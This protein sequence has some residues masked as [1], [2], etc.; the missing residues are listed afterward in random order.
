MSITLSPEE[1]RQFG[2]LFR[3]YDSE[4]TGVI[5]G[6]AAYKLFINSGLSSAQL[7]QIW[8]IA[9]AENRGFLD[10]NGFGKALR[11]IYHVQQG[12][13]LAPRLAT[14]PASLPDFTR[15]AAPAPPAAPAQRTSHQP[16]QSVSSIGSNESIAAQIPP[17]GTSDKQRFGSLFDKHAREGFIDG[18]SARGIFL[19]A[20]LANDAL[21][22]IWSLVDVAGRGSLR[23]NEFILAMHLIQCTMRKSLPVLPSQLPSSW[24]PWLE[25][26]TPWRI[27]AQDKGKFDRHFSQLDTSG[28]GYIGA[29]EAV[30]FLKKSNLSDEDL[31]QVWDL[32]DYKEEGRLDR[33]GFAIAM[34]LINRKL[35]GDALPSR[36]PPELIE[37]SGIQGTAVSRSMSQ[38]VGSPTA[39]SPITSPQ[40]QQG[41]GQGGPLAPP[42]RKGAA[43]SSLQDLVSLDDSFFGK[44][45]IA[46]PVLSPAATG[47]NVQPHTGSSQGA[48]Q[49]S[50]QLSGQQP[51]Q[52]NQNSGS[53]QTPP[54][55]QAHQPV[56]VPKSSFGQ[57]LVKPQQ[58]AQ[59]QAATEDL[60]PL[61]NEKLDLER[62]IPSATAEAEQS[63]SQLNSVQEEKSALEAQ[64]SELKKR[65]DAETARIYS[66]QQ[67]TKSLREEIA[68]LEK[69]F[70]LRSSSFRALE[71]QHSETSRGLEEATSRKEELAS[72]LAQL[73]EQHTTHQ[74]TLDDLLRESQHISG[75]AE[76]HRQR[77][78]S[79]E[80]ELGQLLNEIE[81]AKTGRDE[82]ERNAR[83]ARERA[84][85]IQSEVIKA[86][87][88]LQQ[89]RDQTSS[90]T[91]AAESYQSQAQQAE[92][93]LSSI[94]SQHASTLS[95]RE[96]SVTPQAAPKE[97][98]S[99]E[100]S[101]SSGAPGSGIVGAVGAAAGAV[102]GAGAGI[103]AAF[104]GSNRTNTYR[105]E[106]E[107][108][109]SPPVGTSIMSS[110]SS[111]PTSEFPA[112]ADNVAQ[113]QA[114]TLPMARPQSAT[115][116]VTNNPPQSVRGDVDVSQPESPTFP[117]SE[118]VSGINPPT[119]MKISDNSG[120][121]QAEPYAQSVQSNDSF[122][123]V[124]ANEEQQQQSLYN[125]PPLPDST[126][127]AYSNA[128]AVSQDTLK[129]SGTDYN[130]YDEES[131]SDDE[132]PEQL[133]E[134][135]NGH[136]R[137]T[138][139]VRRPSG[140]AV[141]A[142]GREPSVTEA[143][144]P[145]PSSYKSSFGLPTR[146]NEPTQRQ[147]A[148][149][150]ALP[151]S[152]TDGST[153]KAGS[154]S[155]N[156]PTPPASSASAVPT[157]T[158]APV[159]S[160]ANTS[161]F[162]DDFDDL[163]EAI[164]DVSD[165]DSF[166]GDANEQAM[167]QSR[168]QQAGG[169]DEW[170]QLFTDSAPAHAGKSVPNSAPISATDGVEDHLA[171]NELI[172]MG[173]DRDAAIKAL[174]KTNF[175]VSEATNLLLDE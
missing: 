2:Q 147:A 128:P 157:S 28:S 5:L 18:P 25:G 137:T 108:L 160:K 24:I 106:P 148:P 36:A 75:Q 159:A 19:K 72:Q 126:I 110:P 29:D 129:A 46:S 101:T 152:P 163:Q 67:S 111:P 119:S 87:K 151:I 140:S 26:S 69:D 39:F 146:P 107:I 133:P 74:S 122:E 27:T 65:Y 173:F 32:A 105:D 50:A 117:T 58:Q 54:A 52:S 114:F 14:I 47:R 164:E 68:Q 43:S 150:P 112:A 15:P 158:S 90:Y 166:E 84:E 103:G 167:F 165:E 59:P 81:A 139:Q 61:K 77:V 63:E 51:L 76:S 80:S 120:V 92:E 131:S 109:D 34:Y 1:G 7:H 12:E 135:H 88:E 8:T 62:K 161:A 142:T 78:T 154:L 144:A 64:I 149:A 71:T 91:H 57:S 116:S 170:E 100:A 96:R 86:Q 9:D 174:Q 113:P 118:P 42:H 155:S 53:V 124:D 123:F 73:E 95:T 175:N 3:K 172:S 21:S 93:T 85:H 41:T 20:H 138:A 162:D 136:D 4:G 171:L 145:A 83:V 79:L 143:R 66:A 70:N 89:Y 132:G 35:G 17:L 33:A 10:E 31:A 60:T 130:A 156:V 6:D 104:M 40:I 45:S 48:T 134:F 11:M 56:F 125:A 94:K 23:R 153:S 30:P 97:A 22:R 49:Q 127:P 102:V 13:Q 168:P 82:A 44:T 37:S 38:R 115:S 98:S 141:Y 121:S 55:V 99:T 169:S 16:Q